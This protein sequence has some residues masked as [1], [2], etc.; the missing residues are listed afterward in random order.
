MDIYIYIYHIYQVSLSD[1]HLH[2][3]IGTDDT[4]RRP[5]ALLG[6]KHINRPRN[7]C[8]EPRSPTAHGPP[9]NLVE[10][11]RV[12]PGHVQH[13]FFAIILGQRGGVDVRLVDLPKRLARLRV[14]VAPGRA[15]I[16]GVD[17]GAAGQ[18]AAPGARH[19][20]ERRLAA[21]VH[22][23]ALVADGRRHARHVDD[24]ARAVV[25]QVRRHGLREEE[26][27][28]DVDVVHALELFGHNG[29]LLGVVHELVGGDA[30]VV[31]ENV[32]LEGAG[33]A[34]RGEESLGGLHNGRGGF[35]RLAQVGLQGFAFDLVLR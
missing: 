20:F 31:D 34:V 16:D 30:G 23:L 7:L 33:G 29:A 6:A 25:G 22:R 26:R 18:L 10:P 17:G 8:R 12:R 27:R 2:A 35:G 28:Q 5:P 1:R 13:G 4:A 9:H 32:N 24:A 19:G 14:H 11:L 15:R 21:R 3:A